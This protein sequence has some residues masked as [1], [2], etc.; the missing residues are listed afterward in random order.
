MKRVETNYCL[1][2]MLTFLFSLINMEMMAKPQNVEKKKEINHSFK[3]DNNSCLQVDNKYGNISITHWN[4]EEVSMRIEIICKAN[5]ERIAQENIDRVSIDATMLGNK[6]SAKTELKSS[7]K[8]T[9]NLSI[10]INY[11]IQ[12]PATLK[13]ELSQKYGNIY[14]PEKDNHEMDIEVKYGNLKAGDFVAP[15]S[16]EAKYSNVKVGNLTHAEI[17]LSYSGGASI[18]KAHKLKIDSRYSNTDI[19]QIDELKISSNYGN[20]SIGQVNKLTLELAYGN[21]TIKKL[22][23]TL[24]A[25]ELKYSNLTIH[26]LSPSFKQFNV[27]ARYGNVDVKLPANASFRVAAKEMKYSKC[28]ING[29]KMELISSNKSDNE[30][31]YEINEGKQPTLY[32]NGNNYANLKIE[33]VK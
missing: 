25:D 1:A 5:N 27:D 4:K 26:S 12:M 15:L 17:D 14:L 11:Y 32:F 18:A 16:L 2:L 21:T 30:F 10:N 13:S 29:F 23:E 20:V 19:E 22:N 31:L 7:N 24:N 9:R 28:I 6:I 8:S 3:V 33:A